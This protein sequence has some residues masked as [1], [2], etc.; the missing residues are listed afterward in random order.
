MKK[1]ILYL[2]SGSFFVFLFL[3]FSK[4]VKRDTLT[5]FDFDM[6]VKLQN[7]IPIRVDPFFSF[8]SLLGS[9]EVIIIFLIF[10]LFVAGSKAKAGSSADKLISFIKTRT[11][12]IPIIILFASA[13]FVEI[14]GKAF[15]NHPGPPH[16]FYRYDIPF[17]FPSSYV[18]PGSSYPSGHSMRIIFLS[19]ILFAI[20]ARSKKLSLEL[21]ALLSLSV[22]GIAALM[23]VSRVSL[24]EHWTSDVIGGSVLGLG[25]GLISLIFL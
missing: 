24:G 25:M 1:R 23:L 17:N 18:Q 5:Q 22:M 10:V 8:L 14:I 12:R 6:T 13:H 16:M 4:V 3:F 9:A 21:K 7:H 15:L 2:L 19:V 11:F 20:F